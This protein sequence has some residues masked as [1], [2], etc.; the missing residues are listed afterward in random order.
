MKIL[1]IEPFYNSSH[2]QWADG[3]IRHSRHDIE[4]LYLSGRH[5]KWRMHGAAVTLSQ[6]LSDDSTDYNLIICTDMVDV[7]V[8]K[9]LLPRRYA[10]VPLAV[11]FHENQ[12][13]YPWSETD[14]DVNLQ[15]DNHYGWINYTSA[16]AADH[17][18]F[19]S[20]YHKTAFLENLPSFLDQFPDE[21]HPQT[22]DLIESK[23]SV[24]HIG[25]EPIA[26]APRQNDVPIILWNHRW[27]YDKNPEDFFNTMTSLQDEGYDFRLNIVGEKYKNSPLIFSQA[28]KILSSK[29][30]NWGFVKR[31]KYLEILT[32]SDILPV[33]SNQDFFGI[34]M[35]EAVS[36]GC[37]PILPRRLA[38]PEHLSSPDYDELYYNSEKELLEIIKRILS[39]YTSYDTTSLSKQMEK[40]HWNNIISRYDDHFD[41]ISST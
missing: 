22:I 33:T 34:S 5:W 14:P 1:L 32:T 17:V 11:Y 20:H 18:I 3:L 2:K 13:T 29:I 36:A 31:E 28:R 37:I 6:Q 7:A 21:T 4:L 26:Y 19:N 27:E 25:I 16:L 41:S 35:V 15:R 8:F 10:T 12:I 9:A 24:L 23:S 40:Y 39:N 30:L 38:F